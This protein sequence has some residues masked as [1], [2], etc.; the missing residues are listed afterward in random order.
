MATHGDETQASVS[1]AS[2]TRNGLAIQPK[3]RR[4]ARTMWVAFDP[5]KACER[6]ADVDPLT[7]PRQ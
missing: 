3:C 1:T 2:G 5:P 7:K 4:R 6:S